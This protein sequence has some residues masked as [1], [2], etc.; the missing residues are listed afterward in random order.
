VSTEALRETIINAVIHRDL[1]NASS[2]V[3]IAVFD[4]RIEVRSV[5][6]LPFGLRA[7]QLS[8]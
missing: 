3:A 7:E 2:Y 6:D 8:E 1:S 4:D 5:G